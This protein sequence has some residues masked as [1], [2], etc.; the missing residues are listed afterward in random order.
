[1]ATGMKRTDVNRALR[2]SGCSIK[3]DTGDHT[4]WECPCGSHSANIPGTG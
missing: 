3:S 2:R 4:K 1:M